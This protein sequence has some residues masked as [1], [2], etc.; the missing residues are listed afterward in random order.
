MVTD[1]NFPDCLADHEAFLHGRFHS[2]ICNSEKVFKIKQSNRK[3]FSDRG[4]QSHKVHNWDQLVSEEYYHECQHWLKDFETMP[5]SDVP[6]N[7]FPKVNGNHAL[8]TFTDASFSA[9]A[10]VIY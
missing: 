10:A 6:R 2:K 4:S 7:S 3:I 5:T 1:K 9:L 8:H